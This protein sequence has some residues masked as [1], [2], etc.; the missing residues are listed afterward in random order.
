MTVQADRTAAGSSVP[1]GKDALSP[2]GVLRHGR[3]SGSP[4]RTDSDFL[5]AACGKPPAGLFRVHAKNT[6]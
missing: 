5:R 3:P 6:G 1:R 2:S 4:V